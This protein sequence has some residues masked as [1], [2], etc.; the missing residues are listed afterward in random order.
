MPF[1]LA[2]ISLLVVK[3]IQNNISIIPRRDITAFPPYIL[4]K[5]LS[6][7]CFYFWAY[8]NLKKKAKAFTLWLLNC[9]LK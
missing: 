8:L 4:R 3:E 9:S 6:R 7:L 1:S 2:Y 5:N